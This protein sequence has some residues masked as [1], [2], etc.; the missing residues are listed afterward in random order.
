[1]PFKPGSEPVT[2]FEDIH[3][4]AVVS[5]YTGLTPGGCNV[6]GFAELCL[7]RAEDAAAG[8]EE[9]EVG[10]LFWRDRLFGVELTTLGRKNWAP[11]RNMAFEEFGGP[12][13][14]AAGNE[15]EWKGEK[16]LA[17]LSYSHRSRKAS[18]LIVSVEIGDEMGRAEGLETQ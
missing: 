3:W 18:L 12:P 15:F 13:E 11:F 5:E 1:M 17:H 16:A 2:G 4:G 6:Y 10:L 9:V 8:P 14:P 7:Y